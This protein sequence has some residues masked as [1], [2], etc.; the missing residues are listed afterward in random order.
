MA[1]RKRPRSGSIVDEEVFNQMARCGTGRLA[2]GGISIRLLQEGQDARRHRLYQRARRACLQF[3]HDQVTVRWKPAG[4]RG[5]G[6]GSSPRRSARGL[7]RWGP[8]FCPRPMLVD[9]DKRGVDHGIFV[10]ASAAVTSTPRSDSSACGA[11]SPDRA[12]RS[13]QGPGPQTTGYPSP[14]PRHATGESDWSSVTHTGYA[15]FTAPN[16]DEQDANRSDLTSSGSRHGQT[17]R[18]TGSA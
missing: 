16:R 9:A 18:R 6:V 15:Y 14:C 7:R 3:D 2:L 13:R 1:P 10:V 5:F 4:C 8:P 11:Y 17:P 12:G